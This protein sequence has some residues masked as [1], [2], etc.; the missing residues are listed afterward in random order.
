MQEKK[1]FILYLDSG[2]MVDLMTDEQAGKLAKAIFKFARGIEPEF[3][4]NDMRI[5]FEPF[6]QQMIRDRVK[7]EEKI[8]RL[9]QNGKAGG[10]KSG[11]ARASKKK[12]KEAIASDNEANEADRDSVSESVSDIKN[13]VFPFPE[14]FIPVWESWKTYKKR[15]H[16]F[17]YE[18]IGEE[19]ALSQLF[20]FSDGNAYAA[21]EILNRS[22]ANKWKG[23]FRLDSDDNKNKVVH[24]T[25]QTSI[26]LPE[27]ERSG[28][29]EAIQP[30][31]AIVR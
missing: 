10:V 18:I 22:I 27:S 23:F 13:P 30:T 19:K 14:S 28:G 31:E 26:N 5:I 16:K 1:G 12:Q 11:K 20:N 17:K 29:W 4:N 2:S 3:D 25:K 7:Y 24:G 15:A 6:R 8:K 21:E 9:K